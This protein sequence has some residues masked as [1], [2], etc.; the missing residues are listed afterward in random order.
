M[1]SISQSYNKHSSCRIITAQFVIQQNSG[2][3][4]RTKISKYTINAA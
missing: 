1:A 2:Q 3:Q 4:I